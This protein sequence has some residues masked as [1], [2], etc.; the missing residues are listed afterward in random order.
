MQDPLPLEGTVEDS[1]LEFKGRLS[2]TT[3]DG[4]TKINLW[5]VAKD[6]VAFANALGGVILVGADEDR[7]R[8]VLGQ[9]RP[10]NDVEAK[11][12]RDACGDAVDA[13]CSPKPVFDAFNVPHAQGVIVAVNVWPFPG[14]AVGVRTKPKD[15]GVEDQTEATAF[16]FPVRSGADTIYLTP[17]QLP[18]LMLPELRRVVA[19]LEAIPKESTV[20][21]NTRGS[22][23]EE[24]RYKF[25]G[26]DEARNVVTLVSEP[27]GARFAMP[28]DFVRSVWK[29]EAG[30]WHVT[31]LPMLQG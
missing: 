18:M 30:L 27:A 13:Y 17:E 5:E 28:L 20:A 4:K 11:A 21:Y 19:L 25:I 24:T 7:K 1:V 6:I 26:I 12:T 22:R 31:V 16:A 9:Y 15:L 29:D 2:S 23:T 8:G 3:I 14:Q 10:L